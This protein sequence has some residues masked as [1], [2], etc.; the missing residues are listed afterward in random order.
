MLFFLFY[1]CNKIDN[2]KQLFCLHWSRLQQ[3]YMYRVNKPERFTRWKTFFLNYYLLPLNFIDNENS[4]AL[5]SSLMV[6]I[7]KFSQEYFMSNNLILFNKLN[8]QSLTTTL[9]IH[10]IMEMIISN[11]ESI[12]PFIVAEFKNNCNVQCIN[13]TSKQDH[14]FCYSWVF[15]SHFV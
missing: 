15:H 12:I 1:I 8:N 14:F 10:Y 13:V 2:M 7:L 6:Y 9:F 5:L 11:L 3:S 4:L